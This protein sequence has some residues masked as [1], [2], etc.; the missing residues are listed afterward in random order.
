MVTVKMELDGLNN[1]ALSL[2]EDDKKL[3]EMVVGIVPAEKG[4][5]FFIQKVLLKKVAK[6]MQGSY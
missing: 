2:Y 5:L 1:G 4:Y 6:N 3:G